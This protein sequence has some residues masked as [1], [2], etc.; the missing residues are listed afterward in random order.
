VSRRLDFQK[1]P[2]IF[3]GLHPMCETKKLGT[4]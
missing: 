2:V 1:F 3:P 4:G